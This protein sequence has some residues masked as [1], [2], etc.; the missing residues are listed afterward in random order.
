MQKAH[1]TNDLAT[2]PT[3]RGFQNG[4]V[5]PYLQL[6]PVQFYALSAAN[7]LVLASELLEIVTVWVS[8]LAGM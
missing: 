8:A 6:K 3:S 5:M 2:R 1:K 7:T 4:Y